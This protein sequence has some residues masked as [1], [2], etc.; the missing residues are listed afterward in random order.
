MRNYKLTI[1]FIILTLLCVNNTYGQTQTSKTNWNKLIVGKWVN[2]INKTKDGKEYFGIKC[3]DTIQY[4]TNGNYE[5]Q[6]CDW[7]ETGKWKFSENKELII[8]YDVDNA[9][10]RKEL[11]TDK[12]F[13]SEGAILSITRNELVTVTLDEEKGEILCYHKRIE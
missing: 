11:G 12:L 6:Q 9:Y 3:K 5:S 13:R 2:K 1:G 10:W 8:H 7:S 4:F